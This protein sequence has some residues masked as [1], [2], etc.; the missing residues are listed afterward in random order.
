MAISV[1]D[2]RELQAG[3]HMNVTIG[4]HIMDLVAPS[5]I[6]PDYS[7]DILEARKVVDRMKSQG[8]T[9]RLVAFPEGG[10][11]AWFEKKKF[12]QAPSDE[13]GDQIFNGAGDT[14][15]VAICRAALMTVAEG[16]RL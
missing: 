16:L 5:W 1:K 12:M 6:Y 7:S 14:E 3:P 2:V 11:S 8:W 10:Y 4:Y 9:F 13:I 15:P